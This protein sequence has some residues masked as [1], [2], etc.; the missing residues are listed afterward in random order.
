MGQTKPV[1]VYWLVVK[2]TFEEAIINRSMFKQAVADV[3]VDGRRHKSKLPKII[4]LFR[5]DPEVTPMSG[6]MAACKGQDPLIDRL[7]ARN[8]PKGLVDI[9]IKTV[10][11]PKKPSGNNLDQAIELDGVDKDPG[12]G[13]S[14][15]NAIM[16]D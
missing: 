5:Q 16:L 2:N 6:G 12:V 1:Y 7:L 8:T 3:V 14:A 13:S 9:T 10:P 11:E 15:D 4:E